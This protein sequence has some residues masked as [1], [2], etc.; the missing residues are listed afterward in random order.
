MKNREQ[1]HELILQMGADGKEIYIEELAQMDIIDAT[2]VNKKA[3]QNVVYQQ[4]R[5]L[6]NRIFKQEGKVIRSIRK[7]VYQVVDEKDPVQIQ[8]ELNRLSKLSDRSKIRLNNFIKLAEA[9]GHPVQVEMQVQV[10]T[11]EGSGM[12]AQEKN[13]HSV[14]QALQQSKKPK[15]ASSY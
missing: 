14:T 7:N 11:V 10:F 1:L 3:T 5:V 8:T 2:Y 12:N 9:W 6:L 13:V 4:I 15:K